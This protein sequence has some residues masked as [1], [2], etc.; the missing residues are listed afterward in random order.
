MEDLP[1][2]PRFD[3]TVDDTKVSGH[4]AILP[5]RNVDRTVLDGSS[6]DERLT[7][8]R[9]VRRMW[10]AT[11]DDYVHDTVQVIANLN[12]H[13]CESHPDEG[14]R[15]SEGECRFTS[16]SDQPVSLGW[17]AIEPAKAAPRG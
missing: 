4:T 14:C 2:A 17:K 9:V 13:W 10:E 11:A 16:R 6:E 7:L 3:L 15:L 12:P 1:S 5:T 8:V